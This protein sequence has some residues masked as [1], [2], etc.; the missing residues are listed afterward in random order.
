MQTHHREVQGPAAAVCNHH[1]PR[2][3]VEVPSL[4]STMISIGGVSGM[5]VF[6]TAPLEIALLGLTGKLSHFSNF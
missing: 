5:K 4:S 2:G 3:R 6:V 1:T